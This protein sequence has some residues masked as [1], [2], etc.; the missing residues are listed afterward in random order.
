MKH[1]KRLNHPDIPSH[2]GVDVDD[3]A[4]CT[5]SVRLLPEYRT[6]IEAISRELDTSMTKVTLSAFDLLFDQIVSEKN[7]IDAKSPSLNS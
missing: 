6:A 4:I 7:V 1:R 5:L 2:V 3:R